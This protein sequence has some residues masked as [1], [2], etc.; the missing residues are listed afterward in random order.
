MK[1]LYRSRTEGRWLGVCGGLGVY[2]GVD[3][4]IVRLVWIAASLITGIVPGLV[5]YLVAW[6][7]VPE[8]PA[9]PLTAARVAEPASASAGH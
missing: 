7:V 8:E 6:I 2:F 1:R 9:P 5:V 3:P 4:V